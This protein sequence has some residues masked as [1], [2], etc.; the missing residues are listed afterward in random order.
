MCNTKNEPEIDHINS[1][2]LFHDR[3]QKAKKEQDEAF[4]FFAMCLAIIVVIG[5][6]GSICFAYYHHTYYIPNQRMEHY[7]QRVE[8]YENTLKLA[9][10]HGYTAP[11]YRLV[12]ISAQYV[13]QVAEDGTKWTNGN[14]T[15]VRNGLDSE[16][17]ALFE[18]L[19]AKQLHLDKYMIDH[20]IFEVVKADL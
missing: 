19:E 1:Y 6:I 14:M 18:A 10:P 9:E 15:G 2:I 20:E 8:V 16:I 4:E 11:Q 12:I 5:I 7:D 3:R 13:W 17:K